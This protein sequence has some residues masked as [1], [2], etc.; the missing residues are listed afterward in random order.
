MN[1]ITK[2]G[3]VSCEPQ[4]NV[5]LLNVF[6][7]LIKELVKKFLNLHS[8]FNDTF[9]MFMKE[10]RIISATYVKKSFSI[11][12]FK[13]TVSPCLVRI[14]ILQNFSNCTMLILLT[15]YAS[16]DLNSTYLL[17]NNIVRFW[18]IYLDTFPNYYSRT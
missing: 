9:R 7:H 10:K 11:W 3:N 14:W 4:Y 16:Q 6:E 2:D 17:R 13:N 12:V 8:N 1:H 18:N 15:H 5:C